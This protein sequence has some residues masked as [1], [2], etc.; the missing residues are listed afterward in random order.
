MNLFE[1]LLLAGIWGASFLFMRVAAPELGP[2]P[3]I[4]LRVSIAALVLSPVIGSAAARRHFR[5]KAWPLMVVG[6]T[7]SAVPFSL[8]AYS[9][10][11]VSAGMD[12]VLNATT[13]LWAALIAAAGFQAS[14]VRHQVIGLCVGFAGVVVLVLGAPHA[15]AAGVPL[16][17]AAALA[18]TLLYGFAVNY[19]KRHLSG[20]PPFVVAFGSQFFAAV[21]LLPVALLLWHRHAV[22]PSTWG[23]V[24]ALGVICTG[25]AYI[26]FFRLVEHAGS[27]YAASVT[28]LIPVF[29]MIWG[30]VF[31]GERITPTMLAG[32][33]VVLLGTALASGKIRLWMARRA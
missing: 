21:L 14:L 17:I 30:S 31:L 3:L 1:L 25:L 4:A 9:T 26:L 20:V 6:V 23:C 15:G 2:L 29:G 32:S 27:T 33:A 19:S 22:M 18:A 7:N 11:Y 13:P 24:V 10:L 8:L 5:A 12:S 28:F 16:A